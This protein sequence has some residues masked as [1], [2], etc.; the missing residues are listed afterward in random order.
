[1]SKITRKLFLYFVI[2]SLVLAGTAFAGFY[3]TFR[4]YSYQEY[5]RELQDRAEVIR[6]RLEDFMRDCNGAQE[7]SAYIKVLDDITLADVYF[8]SREG[9]TF[10]CPC[11]CGT[12]VKIEKKPSTQVEQFAQ[13]VFESGQY[14]SLIHI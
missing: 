14:L 1:M 6:A 2:V 11:S 7:L 10:T 4:Y 3:G 12:T 13:Q 8:I 9:E 5:N